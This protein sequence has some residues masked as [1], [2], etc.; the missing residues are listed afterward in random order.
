MEPLGRFP[1][2]INVL[3]REKIKGPPRDFFRPDHRPLG[4]LAFGLALDVAPGSP[5]GNPEGGL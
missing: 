4:F 3:P 1:S 5:L 2:L